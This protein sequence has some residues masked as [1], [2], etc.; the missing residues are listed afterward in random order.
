[1][2]DKE[3]ISE[4]LKNFINPIVTQNATLF[5]TAARVQQPGESINQCIAD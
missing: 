1:M 3:G 2:E 5:L 4:I